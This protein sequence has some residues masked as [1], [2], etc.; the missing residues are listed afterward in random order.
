MGTNIRGNFLDLFGEGKLPELEVTIEQMASSYPSMKDI[1]FN[2]E[3]MTTDIFQTT[4]LSGLENPVIKPEGVPVTFGTIKGGYSKTFTATTYAAGYRISKEAVDD[5]KINFVQRATTSFA[6]GA[7][8]VKEY[9]LASI[10]DDGF[11]VNGYDG[12]PLFSNSHPLENAAALGDNLDAAASFSVTSYRSLRDV[13][14]DTLNE[15]GQL[16]NLTP[17]YLVVPQALQD[18]AAE[19][20]KSQYDPESAN[21]A[22][23]TVYMHTELLPGGFW[24]YLASDTAFFMVAD[25]N[26]HH[27]MYLQRENFNVDSDYDK[28]ARAYEQMSFERYAYGVANWRGVA[29]NAGA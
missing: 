15:D 1:L 6:K 25:K 16:L 24:N 2:Q 29:G 4:T 14:Q 22:I 28:K 11:T 18:E 3:L 7:F 21:N 17:K 10:F 27:L 20:V 13:M 9:N 12:V 19:I 23:N 5:G 26:E 8:E